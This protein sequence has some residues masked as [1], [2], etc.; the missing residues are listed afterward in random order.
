MQIQYGK[1]SLKGHRAENQDR[2]AIE[3][4]EPSVLLVVVDGM[5]GHAEGARA[6]EVTVSC[7]RKH[8]EQ[9]G[10]PVLDPQGFLVAALSD[11]HLQVVGLGSKL[12]VEQRPRATC[13]ACLLQDGFFYSAHIGDSRIYQ[14]R[15][16]EIV[17]RSRDHSHVE[18]L[19]QEGLIDEAEAARHPMR[20]YVECCLGGDD[21]LPDMA[22]GPCRR[23]A[24]GD[25]LALC[26]DGFWTGIGESDL[27]R[28]TDP[29][30]ELDPTLAALAEA[31][32]AANG[33]GSDNTSV[34][35]ARL[36]GAEH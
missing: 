34:V 23:L 20:N 2:V 29:A 7:L 9:A 13:A 27:L 36:A 11:A 4:R 30:S 8:F 32:V 22:I 26:S 24:D 19:L 31:A 10:Q 28:L 6:A 14:L 25:V 5:G 21:P 17:Y 33:P 3:V 1:A 12:A 35:A 18:L 16:G 15:D